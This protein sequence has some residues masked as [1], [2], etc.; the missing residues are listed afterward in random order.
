MGACFPPPTLKQLA[1]HTSVIPRSVSATDTTRRPRHGR[2]P[3]TNL[4]RILVAHR[5]RTTRVR[6]AINLDP[7]IVSIRRETTRLAA[8]G[9][10]RTGRVL[11]RRHTTTT[12]TPLT[13]TAAHS[14][15]ATSTTAASAPNLPAGLKFQSGVAG[16]EAPASAVL[17]GDI[18]A[19]ASSAGRGKP[20]CAHEGNPNC[21]RAR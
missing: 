15:E 19:L 14:T 10:L 21:L 17:E 4:G 18:W 2:A 6:V 1:R 20:A 16:P 13:S 5:A 12:T 11:E 7:A 3:F 8:R 9:F